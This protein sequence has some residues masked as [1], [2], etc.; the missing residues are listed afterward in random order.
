LSKRCCEITATIFPEVSSAATI[1][2]PPPSAVDRIPM[3]A[4]IYALADPR[5]AT[6]AQQAGRAEQGED[7]W[8]P[9]RS[10]FH[11]ELKAISG[12]EEAATIE[13]LDSSRSAIATRSAVSSWVRARA[14]TSPI[15]PAPMR[16]KRTLAVEF[17]CN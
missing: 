16:A 12:A 3:T 14:C 6:V 10:E 11:V 4:V 13:A 7:T 15:T 1:R 5:I 8:G 17:M 2:S 9:N